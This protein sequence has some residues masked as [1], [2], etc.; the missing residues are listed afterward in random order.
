M[1]ILLSLSLKHCQANVGACVT[2]WVIGCTKI[3]KKE[4]IEELI[5]PNN[6]HGRWSI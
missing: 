5:V 2:P 4:S 1:L 6:D 3:L